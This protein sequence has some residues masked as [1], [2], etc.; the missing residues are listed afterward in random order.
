MT[1]ALAFVILVTI[2]AWLYDFYNGMNDAANASP[3]GSPEVDPPTSRRD[4]SLPDFAPL[5]EQGVGPS[6]RDSQRPTM[7]ERPPGSG[8][9]QHPAPPEPEIKE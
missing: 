5:E 9:S 7:T 8:V 1:Q 6:P 2:V 3:T 4:A